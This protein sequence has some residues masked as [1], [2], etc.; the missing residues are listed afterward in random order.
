VQQ[1]LQPPEQVHAFAAE[2]QPQ[3]AVIGQFQYSMGWCELPYALAKL[4]YEL[5]VELEQAQ[6]GQLAAA[7]RRLIALGTVLQGR[8][9]I[10]ASTLAPAGANS[11]VEI[12]VVR[13][14]ALLHG[15]QQ[16]LVGLA[17]QFKQHGW[18][19]LTP[20][21]AAAAQPRITIVDITGMSAQQLYDALAAASGGPVAVLY[22][23]QCKQVKQE[24]VYL[25]QPLPDSR[26]R[27]EEVLAA[28]AAALPGDASAHYASGR[29]YKQS[30][31]YAVCNQLLTFIL[32]D[33]QHTRL[34]QDERTQLGSIL[35][36]GAPGQ[37]PEGSLASLPAKLQALVKVKGPGGGP[38]RGPPGPGAA[39]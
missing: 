14:G 36:S 30:T 39:S 22:E 25:L 9:G 26:A 3:Q 35:R 38:S 4:F 6:P 23:L 13:A 27:F 37:R 12:V 11:A 24:G 33:A 20:A 17:K 16:G 19:V 5:Y 32:A 10:T 7:V 34:P 31:I 28:A 21:A 2:P 8:L 1:L 18:K 29:Y 15:N